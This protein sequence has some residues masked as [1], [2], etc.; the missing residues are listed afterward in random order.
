[1]TCRDCHHF[2]PSEKANQRAFLEGFGY[3]NAAPTIELRARF[4]RADNDC[5]LT[6]PRFQERRA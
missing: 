1:M 4:F 2:L 6:P 3:C 5:W